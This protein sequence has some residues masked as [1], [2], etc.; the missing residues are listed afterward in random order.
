MQSMIWSIWVVTCH[1]QAFGAEEER[2]SKGKH[3]SQGNDLP[4]EK[5]KKKKD[6]TVATQRLFSS[7]IST[8]FYSCLKTT[9][10]TIGIWWASY[11]TGMK[12][13][14]F[15]AP[16]QIGLKTT[17]EKLCTKAKKSREMWLCILIYSGD[18]VFLSMKSIIHM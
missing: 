14:S 13:C 10:Y 4:L 15:T 3:L 11:V 12:T 7:Q 1:N 6:R 16:L 18:R 17:E 9:D 8:T 2:Q 5:K